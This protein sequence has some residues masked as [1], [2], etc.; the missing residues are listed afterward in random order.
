MMDGTP[1]S[2]FADERLAAHAWA[3]DLIGLPW[4]ERLRRVRDD[5]V[6]GTP[7]F[8]ELGISLT[9]DS[10][11]SPA[12]RQRW[13][14][15]AVAAALQGRSRRAE[16]LESFAWA[17]LGNVQR[18]RGLLP[19]SHASF[20][21][22]NALRH[23][24]TDPLELADTLSL[25]ASYWLRISIWSSR[26]RWVD[27]PGKH[28]RGALARAAELIDEALCRATRF[29][30][31]SVIG[32]YQTKAGLMANEARRSSEA[33]TLLLSALD[34]IDPA[35][36][37]R[38]ALAAGENLVTTATHLGRFDTAMAGIL[39]LRATC[40]LVSDLRLSLLRDWLVA[41]LAEARGDLNE[42][43]RLLH[44]LHDT[45][46]KHEM[47]FEAALADLHI[48]KLAARRGLSVGGAR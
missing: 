26:S 48:A 11:L 41:D 28:G 3:A 43:E 1:E 38:L 45:F 4:P 36:H 8:I 46:R 42:A 10:A 24:I 27:R 29:A 44:D 33:V 37:P 19:A 5:R 14:Q 32:C 16:A 17:V 12:E 30:S 20:I 40:D 15:L 7:S 21:R 2:G 35:T 39:R 25:E 23:R 18:V 9:N 13:A 31:D 34:R 22:C 47:P 6:F